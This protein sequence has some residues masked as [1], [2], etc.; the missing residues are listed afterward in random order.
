[1]Q[2]NLKRLRYLNLKG[3]YL[4]NITHFLN[5]CS[6]EEELKDLITYRFYEPGNDI[7]VTTN[8]DDEGRTS[9]SDIEINAGDFYV[10]LYCMNNSKEHYNLCYYKYGNQLVMDSNGIIT[11]D[12]IHYIKQSQ[13]I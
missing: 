11:S 13:I 1:M 3:N 10:Y 9:A 6:Q 5:E 7:Y 8:C 2:D 4:K 12:F